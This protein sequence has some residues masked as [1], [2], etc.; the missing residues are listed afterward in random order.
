MVRQPF[1]FEYALLGFLR[2]KPAYGYEIHQKLKSSEG[3]G[4]VWN[5]KQS[6]L[7]ALLEKLEK[8]RLVKSSL[9][10]QEKRPAR[11]LYHLTDAGRLAL[12]TWL[13]QPVSQPRGMRNEFMAKM[14]FLGGGDFRLELAE[15]IRLQ[16]ERCDHWLEDHQNRPFGGEAW[17]VNRVE[18]YRLRQIE[19]IKDWLDELHKE[20]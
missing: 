9:Q 11:R 5:L 16:L 18:N 7:Y 13:K 8:D 3:L 19:A 6:R 15:L 12:Q 17:F 20:P 14:Y 10:K 1:T 4:I 2:E